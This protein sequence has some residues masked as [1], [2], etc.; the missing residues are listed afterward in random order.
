MAAQASKQRLTAEIE[1]DRRQHGAT[2]E[3]SK[4]P[5]LSQGPSKGVAVIAETPVLG[6]KHV[7]AIDFVPKILNQFTEI[8]GLLILSGVI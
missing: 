1:E 3:Q 5:T 8:A 6:S 2:R 7:A 4:A